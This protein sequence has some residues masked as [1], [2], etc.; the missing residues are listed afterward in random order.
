M[1][2]FFLLL[3]G[4]WK[5]RQVGTTEW[6]PATV[7]GNVFI[8]LH[9]LSMIEN[10][11][12][13]LNEGKTAWVS[14]ESWEYQRNFQVDREFLEAD[15]IDLVC[16]GL[17]TL[18]E[19]FVNDTPVFSISNMFRAYHWDIKSCL[20]PGMNSIRILFKSPILYI[21]EKQKSRR[22]PYLLNPGMTYLRKAQSHF[23]WDWGPSLPG[24]GIWRNIYLKGYQKARFYELEINQ[25]HEENGI[26]LVINASCNYWTQ[27][28]LTF[29][30]VL[31]GPDGKNVTASTHFTD[32]GSNLAY[33]IH[34]GCATIVIQISDPKLWWPNGLGE[35]SLY[36][37][38]VSLFNG[39]E[40]LDHRNYQIGL[41]TVELRRKPDAGGESFQ[42][43]VNGKPMFAKG[44]NWIPA[45]V[46]PARISVEHTEHLIQSAAAANM[47]M[48]RVWG[49]GF[50]ESDEFYNLCD[51]YGILVW[52]DLMFA[53]GV[54]PLD[55]PSFRTSLIQ[56]IEEAVTR[57]RHHACL[58]IWCGSNELESLW[59][60]MRA[61]RS[62]TAANEQFFYKELP[63]MIQALDPNRAFWASSPS[64]GVF[65]ANPNGDTSG[66]THLWEVW[67]GLQ[68]PSKYLQHKSRFVSEFGMQSLPAVETI[69]TFT[70]IEEADLFSPD[71][72]GHQKAEAGNEK[73][74]YYLTSRFR[75]PES[76]VD[77]V[78]L[79]QI[80]QAESVR[81]GVEHWRRSIPHSAGA[82][83]WQLNDCWPA[84]SWS[85][86]DYFGRWKAL[87]YAARR[88]NALIALSLEEREGVV[89][90]HL[91][92]DTNTC[93]SGKVQW[94]LETVQGDILE[95]GIL[96]TNIDPGVP[97]VLFSKD[98][99]SYSL[100]KLGLLFVAELFG[101]NSKGQPVDRQIVLFVPE[102]KIDWQDPELQ[103]EIQSAPK[104][105][106]LV[107]IRTKKLARFI[108]LE[109]SGYSVIFS[110]NCFDLPAG[111][112]KQV[113]FHLPKG[114]TILAARQ[115]LK[116]RSLFGIQPRWSP[117]RERVEHFLAGVRLPNLINRMYYWF[118]K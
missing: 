19:V 70:A 65:L 79:S 92:N 73:L 76:L 48:L 6:H 53:C 100:N 45:D 38:K 54:Y 101:E 43:V 51:R 114:M 24:M 17:D 94:S 86:I 83:Y 116:I 25:Q 77:V 98:F 26:D 47:N 106:A 34:E 29:S 115:A 84:I 71:F 112:I 91:V 67:H 66:D 16:E 11:L 78:Y 58:A 68:E 21:Q 44:A 60:L 109:L 102:K 103:F 74:V 32:S 22:L 57:L 3:S 40:E 110:D 72:D 5:F 13:D 2:N 23:G 4:L 113:T 42:F 50:Y 27:D 82:L 62:L 97:A 7:P 93:W 117:A 18:A 30:I 49:G 1:D 90:V 75:M 80:V 104:G 108:W 89:K 9:A 88:F 118:V 95:N 28:T 41:R 69:S 87:H 31:T 105:D 10:P 46:F 107:T 12:F 61:D 20:N 39:D 111:R 81:T 37:L 99:S 56:E 59:R 8:D 55:I 64:S 14:K 52:Q 63:A 96:D 35:Q 36:Q 15:V 33:S 85:S